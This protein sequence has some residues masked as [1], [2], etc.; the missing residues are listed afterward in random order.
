MQP[1]AKAEGGA[2]NPGPCPHDDHDG[3]LHT[4]P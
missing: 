2:K 1:T 3:D 4:E